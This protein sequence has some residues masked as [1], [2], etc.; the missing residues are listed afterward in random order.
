M[1]ELKIVHRGGDDGHARV[2]DR[3]NGAGHVDQVHHR[4]AQDE[5]QGVGVVGQDDM[6][7]FGKRV[8]GGLGG[9][10][11]TQMLNGDVLRC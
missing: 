10:V 8:G 11:A 1:E 4:A 9:H 5:P 3:R 7:G 2:P 6:D